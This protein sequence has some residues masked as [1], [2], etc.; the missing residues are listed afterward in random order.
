LGFAFHANFGRIYSATLELQYSGDVG[1]IIWNDNYITE[2][3]KMPSAPKAI[4]SNAAEIA[5]KAKEDI[6]DI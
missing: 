5:D 6:E 4:E 1:D 2:E 3:W